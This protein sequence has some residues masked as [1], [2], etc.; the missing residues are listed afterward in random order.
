MSV[1]DK[2]MNMLRWTGT[3]LVFA[4]LCSASAAIS[5][6]LPVPVNFRGTA[7]LWNGRPELALEAVK[8]DSLYSDTLHQLF[9]LGT[10]N[11]RL[12]NRS[13]A[14]AALGKV[15]KQS[16]T[17]APLA[18]EQIGD[19]NS[20]LNENKW[21][22]LAYGSALGYTLPYSYKKMLF[23]KIHELEKKGA[24][25][26]QNGSWLN[27]YQKWAS[28]Q[29]PIKPSEL[30]SLCDSLI[31]M[32]QM[33]AADSVLELHL[34]HLSAREACP[35]IKNLFQKRETDTTVSTSFLFSLAQKSHRCR[36]NATAD[37]LLSSAQKR[38][39]FSTAVPARRSLMLAADIEYDL[40]HFQQAIALYKKYEKEFSPESEVLMQIA[41]AYRKL[42]NGDQA[43]KWY[44]RHIQVFPSHP[45][46][47]E[48]LWLRAW[49]HEERN[50]FKSAAS[51]YRKLFSS[52]G[53]RTE[54]SH[55]R[56]ALC[57]Y[58]RG[59]YD[60]SL[61]YLSAFQK[62]YPESY[63]SAAS[64]FW[65]G[66]C[67]LALGRK[68]N[69]CSTWSVLSKLD[70]TD[71][72]AHR[73][74]QMMGDTTGQIWVDYDSTTNMQYTRTWLDSISPSSKKAISANDSVSLFRGAALLSV[75]LAK[76]AECFL[77]DFET[78]YYGNLLLQFDLASAYAMAGD[79]ALAFRVGRRLSWRI[80]VENRSQVPYDV[81]T[82]LYPDF[83]SRTVLTNAAR[84]AVDPLLICAVIRQESIFD[85]QIVSPAGAVG[86]MQIMPYTGKAISGKLKDDFSTDSLYSFAFNIRYGSYY[87]KELLDDFDGNLV[88]VLASYNAG[89][90]NARKWYERGKDLD[91]DLFVEDI[92]F[93]ETR[94]YVKK[95]LGN[96]W[97]YKSLSQRANHAYNPQNV[98]IPKVQS[99]IA[100]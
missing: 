84:F 19:L 75:G 5:P 27:E 4:M 50:H 77:E 30:E 25:I 89:P 48:I 37:K 99:T 95:V 49:Q 94:G 44:D 1:A 7:L 63:F 52:K 90:H 86:L 23:Q 87:L 39:D 54:E 9:K 51:V 76:E 6:A 78:N 10:I 62:K 60:S 28:K 72:Y 55:L 66:K 83:F 56:H 81:Q 22:V 59:E 47:Q 64:M 42:G 88:L 41:R 18:Y 57:Y 17:L 15:T 45:K 3:A 8:K 70:P 34:S 82:L 14:L 67:L 40:G 100:P 36:D 24:E 68:E 46:S 29:R 32:G 58:R 53:K 97:T 74:R 20:E 71:Y 69:A 85:P 91:S 12:K 11:A 33:A 79:P 92:G 98:V 38:T 21:A 73:A 2:K 65:Q 16:S 43:N 35:I 13:E 80:P 96:Y 31:A 93:T 26:P 61:A